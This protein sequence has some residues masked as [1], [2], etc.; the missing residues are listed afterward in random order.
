[1]VESPGGKGSGSR[2]VA[3]VLQLGERATLLSKGKFIGPDDLPETIKQEPA[4]PLAGYTPTSLKEALAGPEKDI[5]R[6]ALQ[7][8]H[9]N[10]QATANALQ[11]I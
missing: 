10:R 9:W 2:A 6:R 3:D 8:N 11:I 1:M 7:A 5:I 4:R